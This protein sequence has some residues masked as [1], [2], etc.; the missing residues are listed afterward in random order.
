MFKRR[1]TATPHDRRT[2]QRKGWSRAS[3]GAQYKPD[4]F[5]E[6]EF[7]QAYQLAGTFARVDER[8]ARREVCIASARYGPAG[9]AP[10]VEDDFQ[11]GVRT[12]T[13]AYHG[14]AVDSRS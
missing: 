14:L 13:R 2:P 4:I 10:G 9:S 11:S 6:I 8:R 12:A 5:E 3:C 7:R 1:I